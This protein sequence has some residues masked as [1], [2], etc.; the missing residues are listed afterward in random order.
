VTAGF[1]LAIFIGTLADDCGCQQG[2]EKFF[3]SAQLQEL[4]GC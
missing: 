4:T 3:M 1:I 2:Q